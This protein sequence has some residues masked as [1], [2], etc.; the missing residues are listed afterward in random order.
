MKVFG[1]LYKALNIVLP[2]LCASCNA[3]VQTTHGFC[4]TCWAKLDFITKP[5]CAR[6]GIPFPYDPDHLQTQTLCGE[7][8]KEEP[9]FTLARAALSYTEA[10][11]NLLLPFKH[12]DATHLAPA[13]ATLMRQAGPDVLATADLFVPVPLYWVRLLLRRYN[14]SALLARALAQASG[15]AYAPD[16]LRRIRPT[17]SQGRLSRAQ[18]LTNVRGAFAVAT[19][20]QKAI[21]G[22][23]IVLVDDVLT[24]GATANACAKAL[25]KAG[26]LQVNVL[27]VARVAKSHD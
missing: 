17:P 9:D 6:C 5:F 3:R 18:R 15:K 20:R 25:L 7:C 8:L 14:Q 24:T 11:R 10:S 2:P 21:A 13:L 22:K 23:T 26:A 1:P 16:V 19:G 27:T 4:G 12:H